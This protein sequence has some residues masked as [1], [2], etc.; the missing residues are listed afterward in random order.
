MD[1]YDHTCIGAEYKKHSV[2]YHFTR[3]HSSIDPFSHIKISLKFLFRKQNLAE[4]LLVASALAAT[5][6]FNG[7]F[8]VYSIVFF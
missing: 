8:N 1:K 5:F 3:W 6:Y 4:P 7:K 2:V